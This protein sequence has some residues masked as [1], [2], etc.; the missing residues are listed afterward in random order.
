MPQS[1][2]GPILVFHVATLLT[3]APA[4]TSELTVE[5]GNAGGVVFVGALNR[6]DR[7]GNHRP[8]HLPDPKA[9]IDAPAVDAKAVEKSPG[10]WVFKDLPKGKYDLVILTND[11]RRFEGFQY[12]PVKEFDP[13]FPQDASVD[14]EAR[15]TILDDIKKS[16]H[17]ENKIEPLYLGGD[18]KAVRVLVALTRDQPTSYE[19]DSPGA[20]T[21]RH[22]IWQYSF[23]YGAWKKEKRTKVLDRILMPRDE[24]R[25]WTWRWDPKLGGIEVGSRPITVKFDLSKGESGTLNADR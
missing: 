17:Y 2:L 18:E 11:R 23:S 16:P 8:E 22:E 9:K 19:A 20:A 10:R 3:V 13:L 25:R 15:A 14:D 24:L 4:L 21:V 6:W 12:V 5:L 7:D 1:S